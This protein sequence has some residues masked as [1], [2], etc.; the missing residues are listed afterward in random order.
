MQKPVVFSM[1]MF[2]ISMKYNDN[3]IILKEDNMEEKSRDIITNDSKLIKLL[4]KSYNITPISIVKESDASF[5]IST[6]SQTL[7]LH[8]C[9][10]NR[11]SCLRGLY[12]Q[13]YLMNKGF[14]YA[15]DIV[16][17]TSGGNYVK[18]SH[19]LYYIEKM[20]EG[21]WVSINCLQDYK[22]VC[23]LAGVFHSYSAVLTYKDSPLKD[24]IISLSQKI[25]DKKAQVSSIRNIIERKR[26]FTDFDRS[27][28][29]IIDGLINR[30]EQCSE[31]SFGYEYLCQEARQKPYI[32]HNSLTKN[33]L[34]TEG[35]EF[36]IKSFAASSINIP[37]YELSE[38]L[39]SYMSLEV[40]NWDF[41][42]LK[43]LIDAY[44][45]YRPLSIN[46]YSI[47]LCL[48]IM[49][50]K[51]LNLGRKRY[52]KQKSWSEKKYL[53]RLDKALLLFNKQ[54]QFITP[55]AEFYGILLHSGKQ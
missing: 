32:C 40:Y 6:E 50:D 8:K 42:T 48:L 39:K 37:I 41:N 36:Y 3:I 55:F 12:I 7:I 19:S 9:I 5:I 22:K 46:E 26:L 49:P 44:N 2:V 16:K 24:N 27:Y 15:P 10:H 45:E 31:L 17:N 51:L 14:Q 33:L 53:Q 43:E 20:V 35:G 30:L 1:V 23:Q 11:R 54:Q 34:R 47:L 4:R 21:T 13:A 52:L 25:N 28:I 38:L 29:S 18:L